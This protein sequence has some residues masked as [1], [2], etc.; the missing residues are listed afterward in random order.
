M[1]H[2]NIDV[3]NRCPQEISVKTVAMQDENGEY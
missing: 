2:N 1:E 3:N